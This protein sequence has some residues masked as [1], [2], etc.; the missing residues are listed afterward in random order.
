M[1]IDLAKANRL[2]SPSLLSLLLFFL[3][4]DLEWT[5]PLDRT[6]FGDK[7]DKAL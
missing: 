1:K 2:C 7:G 4:V 3:G 5:G 6:T